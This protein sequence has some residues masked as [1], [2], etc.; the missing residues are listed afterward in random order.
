[1]DT[2]LFAMFLV[3]PW[4]CMVRWRHAL[5]YIVICAL[6]TLLLDGSIA[7]W[8]MRQGSSQMSAM[9]AIALYCAIFAVGA[10][11]GAIGLLGAFWSGKGDILL[12]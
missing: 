12:Y 8:A 2:Y 10:A 7:S 6:L 11:F 9:Y 5:R 1:M 3:Y 4:L